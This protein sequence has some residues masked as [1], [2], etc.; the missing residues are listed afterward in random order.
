MRSIPGMVVCCPCDANEMTAAVKALLEYEG[1]AYL[2]LGRLAVETVTDGIPGY[3]FELGKG[4][5][6]HQGKD[7]TIIAVGMMVQ[8]AL[9][10]AE[11]LAEEGIDARVIDMHTIK[12]L[13]VELVE[14]AARE[15]GCIVT[16]E[17]HNII[18]GL[19]EA[20]AACV[21][22]RCPVPMV[23]HGVEDTFGRSGK[24]ELVL[25]KYGL[26]P[27]GIAAKVRRAMELKK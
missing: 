11:F 24:A 22:E 2:R 4:I 25:E 19:G 21:A 16:T 26:T 3:Q 8:K 7:V 18:G 20:V 5:T 17:E 13:D 1:P 14:K 12:P 10:A 27:E 23:R 15:T 6:V 9:T